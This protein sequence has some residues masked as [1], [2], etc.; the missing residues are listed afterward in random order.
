MRSLRARRGDPAPVAAR[1]ARGGGR[2]PR[3]T[4]A[5]SG[6]PRR[7]ARLALSASSSLPSSNSIEVC[8]APRTRDATVGGARR[9]SARSPRM[10]DAPVGRT[11]R[12][13]ALRPVETC[14]GDVLLVARLRRQCDRLLSEHPHLECSARSPDGHRARDQRVGRRCRVTDA[15]GDR[16]R[17]GAQLI[18]WLHVPVVATGPGEAREQPHPQRAVALGESGERLVQQRDDPRVG[19][20]AHPHEA[21][22]VADRCPRRSCSVSRDW[23]ARSAASRNVAFATVGVAA[24]LCASPSD[25]SSSI[26]SASSGAPRQRAAAPSR[27]GERLPRTRAVAQHARRRAARTSPLDPPD[28]RAGSRSSASRA[29]R[30]EGRGRG[31]GAPRACVRPRRGD[32]VA[33][34]RGSPGTAPRT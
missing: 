5:P 18:A 16:D 30:A 1:R 13:D 7:S 23:R 10:P 26:R 25:R 3:P 2:R 33:A 29:R 9:R 14:G 15:R 12:E 20:G 8:T 32:G 19:S 6:P 31:R 27:R 24:R 17:L 21:P 11:R 28:R 22:A 4:T 34:T